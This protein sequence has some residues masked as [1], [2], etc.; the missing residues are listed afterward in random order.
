MFRLLIPVLSRNYPSRYERNANRHFNED[1]R[2]PGH[3]QRF[4]REPSSAERD[5]R[6][7]NWSVLFSVTAA[8]ANK[9][10]ERR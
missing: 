1:L 5:L 9:L 7:D 10:F 3:F 2:I 8:A 6:H 4:H